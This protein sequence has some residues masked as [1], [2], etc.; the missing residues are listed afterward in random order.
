MQIC[1]SLP[2]L[3]DSQQRLAVRLPQFRPYATLEADDVNDCADDMR[4]EFATL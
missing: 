1:D 2:A 4:S 3:M